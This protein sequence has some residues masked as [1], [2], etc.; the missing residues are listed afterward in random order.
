MLQLHTF[1]LITCSSLLQFCRLCLKKRLSLWLF[2]SPQPPTP[3]DLISWDS[4]LYWA[5][6]GIICHLLF[7]LSRQTVLVSTEWWISIGEILIR[8]D[9]SLRDRSVILIACCRG[10]TATCKQVT[11]FLKPETPEVLRAS[12]VW[13]VWYFASMACKLMQ[14]FFIHFIHWWPD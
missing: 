4:Q 8:L 2:S 9:F 14:A 11:V 13:L 7:R 10:H 3:A 5:S 12:Q 1:V 6:D